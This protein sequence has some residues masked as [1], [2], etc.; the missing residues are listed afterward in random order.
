V[1]TVEI[2]VLPLITI[3]IRPLDCLHVITD[4]WVAVPA[5]SA[6][7]VEARARVAAMIEN[8]IS[9]G[10]MGWCCMVLVLSRIL[11]RRR[12][13]GSLYIRDGSHHTVQMRG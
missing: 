10:V 6:Q 1:F 4:F 3:V 12:A 9:G 7:T 5:G 11:R 13:A 2:V 8:F